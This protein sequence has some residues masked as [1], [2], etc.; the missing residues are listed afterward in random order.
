M[1]KVGGQR[2]KI[3][4]QMRVCN[5]GPRMKEVENRLGEKAVRQ[6]TRSQF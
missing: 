6:L 4:K 5:T 2:R 1:I 3:H